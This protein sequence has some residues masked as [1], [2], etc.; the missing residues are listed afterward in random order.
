MLGEADACIAWR[1]AVHVCN[2]SKL[3]ETERD[4]QSDAPMHVEFN[5]LRDDTG[6]L[7][8]QLF[9]RQA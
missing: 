9:P 8:Y 6:L 7:R 4:Q 2:P 1:S 5:T 3:V